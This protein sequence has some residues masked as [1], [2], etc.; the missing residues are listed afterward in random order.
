M[1]T[2]RGADLAVEAERCFASEVHVGQGPGHSEAGNGTQFK[3]NIYSRQAPSYSQ[4][5][6][7]S[8][9]KMDSQIK[10]R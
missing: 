6:K 10:Y 5:S 4:R 7:K 3:P 8:S 1:K 2:V 9:W